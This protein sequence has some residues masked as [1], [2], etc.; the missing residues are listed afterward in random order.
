MHT[1]W[2]ILITIQHTK[3][4]IC[5]HSIS[6][7]NE[8]IELK[9]DCHVIGNRHVICSK[10]IVHFPSRFSFYSSVPY[11]ISDFLSHE[12]KSL[13][14]LFPQLKVH[15]YISEKIKFLRKKYKK[16]TNVKRK[17]RSLLIGSAFYIDRLKTKH[18]I[19]FVWNEISLIRWLFIQILHEIGCSFRKTQ[20]NHHYIISHDWK[21]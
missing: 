4:W 12:S 3:Q 20:K 7:E 18:F 8:R 6:I 5:C 15:S 16:N 14:T 2:N 17:P 21:I 1:T 13:I 10:R 11:N 19:N 9:C